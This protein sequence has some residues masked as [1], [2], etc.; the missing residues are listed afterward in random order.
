MLVF[1]PFDYE[2]TVLDFQG[3]HLIEKFNDFGLY[4]EYAIKLLI[5]SFHKLFNF[6]LNRVQLLENTVKVA[7][8][9]DLNNEFFSLPGSSD[10][11][12]TLLAKL[13]QNFNDTNKYFENLIVYVTL[14]PLR[15]GNFIQSLTKTH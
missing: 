7:L 11:L 3:F 15:N 8:H 14:F 1:Q 6:P 9:R 13:N 12:I 10:G 5:H 4:K 2:K